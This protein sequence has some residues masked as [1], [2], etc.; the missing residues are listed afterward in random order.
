MGSGDGYL[1]N[2]SFE[3]AETLGDLMV[4]IIEWV[5]AGQSCVEQHAPQGS[6]ADVTALNDS[7]GWRGGGRRIGMTW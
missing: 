3:H 7:L 2:H 4:P 1:H 6:F 5:V